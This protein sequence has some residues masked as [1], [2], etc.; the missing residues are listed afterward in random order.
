MHIREISL[1]A[2]HEIVRTWR[3]TLAETGREPAP[4]ELAE[5]LDMPLDIVRYAI[6]NAKNPIL[7][8]N[9]YGPAPRR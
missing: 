9:P 8:D 5:Q 3:E 2:I 7:L 1:A 6:N 4:E